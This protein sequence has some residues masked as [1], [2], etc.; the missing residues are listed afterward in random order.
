MSE[1]KLAKL[2]RC[3]AKS[4][5]I[6]HSL[7]YP[8]HFSVLFRS[9]LFFSVP[10]CFFPFFSVPFCSFLFLQAL[11]KL[12]VLITLQILTVLYN[13][14]SIYN[15]AN[16]NNIARLITLYFLKYLRRCKYFPIIVLVISNHA[17]PIDKV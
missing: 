4:E 16:N 9:F 2:R 14:A 3:K 17:L 6:N 7:N 15:F 5:T 13:V 11:A 1:N 8:V 12:H 10:F